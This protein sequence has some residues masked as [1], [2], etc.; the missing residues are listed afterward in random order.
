MIATVIRQVRARPTQ[1][2]VPLQPGCLGPA[3]QV[4]L[5]L[6][7]F[8]S[9]ADSASTGVA[10]ERTEVRPERASATAPTRASQR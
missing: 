8:R 5:T 10:S 3:T 2:R 6:I 9:G 1:A 4:S 7:N